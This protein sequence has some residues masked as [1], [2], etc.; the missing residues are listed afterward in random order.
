MLVNKITWPKIGRVTKPGL[1]WLT[2]GWLTVTAEDIAIWQNYPNAA[3]TM[4][5]TTTTEA[6]EEYRLGAFE[7]W[8]NLSLSEK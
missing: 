7:V 2:F 6:K 4:F 1:Y 8:Q 5:R 3:F